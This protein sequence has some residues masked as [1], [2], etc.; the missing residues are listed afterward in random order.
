MLR[1]PSTLATWSLL[2]ALAALACDRTPKTRVGTT[3][4][5]AAEVA[6]STVAAPP[7]DEFPAAAHGDIANLDQRLDAIEARL[8][9][10]PPEVQAR[11]VGELR[12]IR[13]QRDAL[14]DDLMTLES[15]P[16]DQWEARR[17]QLDRDWDALLTRVDK[18][19]D[20]F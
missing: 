5:T 6:P 11:H 3:T 18:L 15:L 14:A 9:Q 13:G 8:A 7:A 2:V 10:Q 20:S 4:V 12:E 1:S 19:A 16:K 17:P